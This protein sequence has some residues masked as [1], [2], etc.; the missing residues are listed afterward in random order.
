MGLRADSPPDLS[1][2]KDPLLATRLVSKTSS[3][4]RKSGAF[5]ASRP[6]KKPAHGK[7]DPLSPG[8]NNGRA[9]GRSSRRRGNEVP[10]ARSTAVEPLDVVPGPLPPLDTSLGAGTTLT[11]RAGTPPSSPDK[12]SL[13]YMQSLTLVELCHHMQKHGE[14]IGFVYLKRAHPRSSVHDHA[15]NLRVVPHSETDSSEYYTMSG[16]GVTHVHGSRS[17]F[18]EL[19]RW[20][21]EYRIFNRIRQMP[22]LGNFRLWKG[23]A[24][25]RKNIIDSK[26]HDCREALEANLFLLHHQLRPALLRVQQLCLDI[27]EMQLC[28]IDPATSYDLDGFVEKQKL[29]VQKVSMSLGGFRENVSATVLAACKQAIQEAGFEGVSL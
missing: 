15:Y 27:V 8:G 21:K 9:V 24:T 29:Q 6:K 19:D 23:F 14:E 1:R 18:T 2:K 5:K 3:P 11:T 20:E 10:R 26:R 28:Q 17:D 22:M 16:G 4:A 25:W 13:E 7:L 12:T